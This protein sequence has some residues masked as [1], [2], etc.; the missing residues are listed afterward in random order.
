M[1]ISRAMRRDIVLTG[2]QVPHSRAQY[3]CS[4]LF[5]LVA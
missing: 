2:C 3:G 4:G 5:T 1:L